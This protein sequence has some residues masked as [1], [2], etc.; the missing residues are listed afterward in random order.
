MIADPCVVP[1]EESH[2]RHYTEKIAYM[3]H[4]YFVNDHRQSSRYIL[5][6]NDP[7]RGCVMRMC[8]CC[9]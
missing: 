6:E 2:Q 5:L 4:S 7:V 1:K 9:V 3:P 8:V